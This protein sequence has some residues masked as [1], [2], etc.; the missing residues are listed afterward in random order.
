LT[1]EHAQA[2]AVDVGLVLQEQ[3][4]MLPLVMSLAACLVDNPTF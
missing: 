2:T 4:L 1:G 3:E